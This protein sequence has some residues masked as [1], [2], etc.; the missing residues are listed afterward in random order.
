MHVK[1]MKWKAKCKRDLVFGNEE[2]KS[3]RFDEVG[4]TM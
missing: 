4:V 3:F 2:V 1:M